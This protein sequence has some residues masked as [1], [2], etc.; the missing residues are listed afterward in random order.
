VV[1]TTARAEVGVDQKE[2]GKNKRI[3]FVGPVDRTQRG[4]VFIKLCDDNV[5]PD[6]GFSINKEGLGAL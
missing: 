5:R 4:A 2:S 6:K 3:K 1:H